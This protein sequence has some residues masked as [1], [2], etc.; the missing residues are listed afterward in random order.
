MVAQV[1]KKFSSKNFTTDEFNNLEN[2][3]VRTSTYLAHLIEE[4]EQLSS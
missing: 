1:M 2:N 3:S 4:D